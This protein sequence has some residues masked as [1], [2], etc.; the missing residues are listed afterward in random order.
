MFASWL[1][2]LYLQGPRKGIFVSSKV[3]V[4]ANFMRNPKKLF[5]KRYDHH[6]SKYGKPRITDF[7]QNIKN[8]RVYVQGGST[9]PISKK[10]SFSL[11]F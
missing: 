7:W 9:H 4:K 3:H 8:F 5:V 10:F 2:G 11:M 6:G 1:I